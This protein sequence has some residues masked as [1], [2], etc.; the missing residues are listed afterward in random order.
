MLSEKEKTEYVYK[1]LCEWVKQYFKTFPDK[2]AVVGISGGK[3]STIAAA[4]LVEVLG[5][6]KVI[7]VSIPNGEQSDISDVNKVFDL[8]P[9]NRI[10]V[11]IFEAYNSIINQVSWSHTRQS[12]ENLPPRLRMAVLYA[13]AQNENGLVINTCNYSE[14]YLGWSTKW[15][16]NAGDV[17]IFMGIT[18][19]RVCAIGELMG[20]PKDLVYKVP[21][22]GLCGKTDEEKFG[23][24]YEVLDNYIKEGVCIDKATINKIEQLHSNT[25]HKDLSSVIPHHI[26]SIEYM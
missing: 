24:T 10:D 4:L 7:G 6:E 16:D 3:D 9:I 13:V 2:N 1:E 26:F 23:F 18:K 22:D 14:E 8:L 21:S 19:T 12:I 17:S 20:L 11:N 25:K 5:P 15:G